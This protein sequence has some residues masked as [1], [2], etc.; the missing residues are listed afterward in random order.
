MERKPLKNDTILGLALILGS[1]VI[2]ILASVYF[3]T[4]QSPIPIAVLTWP[5][6]GLMVGLLVVLSDQLEIYFRLEDEIRDFPESATG[7]WNSL[8]QGR[9]NQVHLYMLITAAAVGVQIGLIVYFQKWAASWGKINVFIVALLVV[10][11]AWGVIFRTSW[12]QERRKRLSTF[13]FLIPE[14]G[15]FLCAV[16]GVIYAEPNLIGMTRH[17]R[18]EVV[19]SETYWSNTRGG[20]GRV[21]NFISSD[22]IGF[23]FDFD[24]DDEA[25]LILILIVIVVVC[26]LAS[27][28]L[29]HFWLIGTL[30]LLTIMAGITLRELLFVEKKPVVD[31]ELIIES[32]R[33]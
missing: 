13:T 12:F 9:I 30:L 21:F 20:R 29:P 23:D 22:G 11:V 10:T 8:K 1:F 33:N 28:N 5:A 3:V 25:C 15:W 27:A 16:I 31:Q 17:Q 26:V 4:R 24:C 32:E 19:E 7:F 2:A 18:R 6:A 14:F